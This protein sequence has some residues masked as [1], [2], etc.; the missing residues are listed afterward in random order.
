MLAEVSSSLLMALLPILLLPLFGLKGAAIGYF[1]GFAFYA[2]VMLVVAR[3]RCGH[4]LQTRTL[5][6]FLGAAGLLLV[7]Q[8]FAQ[9]VPG[10]Y[11]GSLPT[12]LVAT[13]CFYAYRRVL[14]AET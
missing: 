13:G 9:I 2:M 3:R 14:S 12:G 7:A 11:W 10:A 8:I 5:V 6:W 4:W 1:A